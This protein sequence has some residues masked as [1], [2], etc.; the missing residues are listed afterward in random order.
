MALCR[1][2]LLPYFGPLLKQSISIMEINDTL[3]HEFPCLAG[4]RHV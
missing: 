3:R 2:R 4:N 1:D